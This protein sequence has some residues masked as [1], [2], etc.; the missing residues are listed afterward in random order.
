MFWI[1]DSDAFDD[2]RID[3]SCA[4]GKTTQHGWV[5]KQALRHVTDPQTPMPYLLDR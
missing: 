4:I 1:S 5:L 3:T 2:S